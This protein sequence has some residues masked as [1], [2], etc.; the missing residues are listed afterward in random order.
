MNFVLLILVL[1]ANVVCYIAGF[2]KGCDML[3]DEIKRRI[4]DE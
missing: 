2:M 3:M 1:I 4:D